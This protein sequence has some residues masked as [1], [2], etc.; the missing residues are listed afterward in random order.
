[1]HYRVS[2]PELGHWTHV[3]IIIYLLEFTVMV[4]TDQL[5][6]TFLCFCYILIYSCGTSDLFSVNIHSL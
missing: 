2:K 1:M 6:I 5:N 4:L 3:T